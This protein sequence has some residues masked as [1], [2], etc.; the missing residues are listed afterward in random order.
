MDP[1]DERLVELLQRDCRV[2][3]HELGRGVGLSVTAV[4]ARLTKLRGRGDVRAYTA[5]VRP[6]SLGLEVCAFVL[7]SVS[8]SKSDKTFTSAVLN[9]REVEECHRIASEF[10]YLLKIRT[11]DLKHLDEFVSRN[12][13]TLTGVLAVQTMVVLSSARDK[14]AGITA[15][16]TALW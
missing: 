1:I 7:L 11:R 15:S 14:A 8:G 5:L 10:S 9:L 3:Y 16:P 4:R 2:P 12:V 6:E 13:K